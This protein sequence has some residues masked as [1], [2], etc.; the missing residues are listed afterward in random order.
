MVSKVIVKEHD[1]P[2]KR[3]YGNRQNYES[4]KL[5][6]SHSFRPPRTCLA[7]KCRAAAEKSQI[8]TP[9]MIVRSAMPEDP[10][11]L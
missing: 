3:R 7:A 6:I 10:V 4:K 5:C 11:T 8:T 9:M 1:D 2:A